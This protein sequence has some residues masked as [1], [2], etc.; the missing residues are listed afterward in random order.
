[1]TCIHYG[2]NKFNRGLFQPVEN[3]NW[4]KPKSGGLWV[5]PIDSQFGWKEWC[6]NADFNIDKLAYN[7]TVKIKNDANGLIINSLLDLKE[8]IQRLN[9]Q[10]DAGYGFVCLDFELLSKHFNYIY[11][12]EKGQ[13]ETRY[14]NPSL[15][16]W[17][18]ES[19]LIMN[20]DCIY[21]V[22]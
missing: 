9:M 1:M 17:D 7:F 19:I 8:V 22:L 18:C 13:I 3:G 12:T 2:A 21:D 11:L 6:L 10:T 4:I 5:S 15:Y 14:S 20:P 16:G